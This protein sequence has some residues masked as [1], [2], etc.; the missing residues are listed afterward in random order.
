M[1]TNQ[2]IPL[3]Q[4]CLKSAMMIRPIQLTWVIQMIFSK[5][6]FESLEHCHDRL[7]FHENKTLIKSISSLIQFSLKNAMIVWLIQPTR[8]NGIISRNIGIESIRHAQ[9]RLNFSNSF[10]WLESF[11]W[12][13]GKL[14]Q[15]VLEIWVSKKIMIRLMKM[16]WDTASANESTEKWMKFW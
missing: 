3:T 8:V 13:K 1:K 6:G 15:R 5:I 12:Y 7:N 9:E 10:I 16:V 4:F 11:G 14:V 2:I